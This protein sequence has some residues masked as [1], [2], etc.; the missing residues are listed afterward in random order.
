MKAGECIHL[1]NGFVCTEKPWQNYPCPFRSD[2]SKCAQCF[3]VTALMEAQW[4]EN[5]VVM[6]NLCGGAGEVERD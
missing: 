3:V 6:V 5:G 4:I 2:F 1:A